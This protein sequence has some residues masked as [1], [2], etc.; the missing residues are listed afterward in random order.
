M[1]KLILV[2]TIFFSSTAL[3]EESKLQIVISGMVDGI[4]LHINNMK[5]S[6]TPFIGF[7]VNGWSMFSEAIPLVQKKISK[8]RFNNN[9]KNL[10]INLKYK[11]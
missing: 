6:K 2:L 5:E 7:E 10:Y 8:G 1:K 9:K 4:P 11:F 3:S